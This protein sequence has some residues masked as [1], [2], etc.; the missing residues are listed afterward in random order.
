MRLLLG[1]KEGSGEKRS[2]K[3]ETKLGMRAAELKKVAEVLIEGEREVHEAKQ[4]LIEANLRFVISIAKRYAGKGLN[5]SDLIQEGNIGLMR[6]VDKFD[7]KRGYKFS[8][9]ATWWIR[10]ANNEGA[11]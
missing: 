1:K 7:Y 2:E 10:Q 11:H 6:A 3:R 8:T 4:A 9:Y 5:F